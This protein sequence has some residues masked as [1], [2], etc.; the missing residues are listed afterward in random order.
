VNHRK[1]LTPDSAFPAPLQD[2]LAAYL[3][4]LALGFL[5]E[6]VIFIGDSSGAHVWLALSRYLA[7][8][9]KTKELGVGMPGVL[10]LV[11]VRD[12]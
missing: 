12:V 10:M 2:A 4:V 11:S 9:G 7:E 5:S 3:Y 6:N 1:T 8:L